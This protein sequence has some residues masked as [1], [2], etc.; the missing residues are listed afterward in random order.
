[1]SWSK[2]RPA[3]TLR[4][5][6]SG[7]GVLV[8]AC[9]LVVLTVGFTVVLDAQLRQQADATLQ[10]RAEAAATTVVRSPGG[11]IEVIETDADTAL[12]AGIWVYDG[13]RPVER[14]SGPTSVQ[15]AADH[16]ATSPGSYDTT[17]S[18]RLYSARVVRDGTAI[19][20]VVASISLTAYEGAAGTAIAGTAVLAVMVIVGAYVVLRLAA[21]RALR[22]VYAMSVQAAAWAADARPDRFGRH[23]RYRELDSLAGNLDAL[24]D[25][26]AAV[27]RHERQL[28][29]ELSHELRTPLSRIVS[30]AELLARSREDEGLAAIRASA[31][32]MSMILE[33][34]LSS[35]RAQYARLPGTCSLASV[36]D[37]LD[38]VA[39]TVV[40]HADA[41]VVGVDAAV[42][43]RIF[44]P[45]FDNA[46][47]YARTAITVDAARADGGITVD[48]HSDGRRIPEDLHERVFEPGFR[49]VPDDGHDGAGLGLPLTRRLARA[50]DGDVTILPTATGTTVR[51][52]LPPG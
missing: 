38:V 1:M 37:G 47:R 16:L 19:A 36:L 13:S 31:Q 27:L 39:D 15:A 26:L 21:A 25:H 52:V 49:A 28:S 44:A 35:A 3:P 17:G 2:H 18:T 9:W 11:E 4:S 34:L 43:A 33:T 50:V 30:E 10:D 51:V 12:D 29:A 45:I 8:I 22:P 14:G 40:I 6:V 23:Q 20:T 32:S 42:A 48:I 24:L 5:R 7:F 46:R 41:D